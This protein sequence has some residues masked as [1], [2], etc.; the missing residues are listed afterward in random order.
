MAFFL[1]QMNKYRAII[2]QHFSQKDQPFPQKLNKLG[3]NDLVPVG[4]FPILH[5]ILL[6]R[7][8]GIDID[9]FYFISGA[10]FVCSPLVFIDRLQGHEVVAK[11]E[12][13]PPAVGGGIVGVETPHFLERCFK[14]LRN[15]ILF[16]FLSLIDKLIDLRQFNKFRIL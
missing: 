5:K 11:D 16:T 3:A 14:G 15:D 1:V 6:C 4:F 13:V 12:H 8:R 10:I 9:K 7:K 2:R